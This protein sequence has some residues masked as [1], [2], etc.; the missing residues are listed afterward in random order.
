MLTLQDLLRTR[1]RLSDYHSM[2]DGSKLYN[3]RPELFSKAYVRTGMWLGTR[4][5]TFDDLISVF[6]YGCN[7]DALGYFT[8]YLDSMSGYR[9]SGWGGSNTN[10]CYYEA[11]EFYV[12]SKVTYTLYFGVDNGV[13]TGILID[14]RPVYFTK[15]NVWWSYDWSR[16]V[17]L[18]TDFDVGWHTVEALGIE[19]CCDGGRSLAIQ[20][21][22]GSITIVSNINFTLRF[23]F[24]A[25]RWRWFNIV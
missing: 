2:V 9:N 17:R 23:P 24:I 20:P 15:S 18:T 16:A 25:S 14:G 7:L 3:F 12:S 13:A 19:D 5:N 4:P 11:Y 21:P 6:N 8:K 22:S 1:T 10:I